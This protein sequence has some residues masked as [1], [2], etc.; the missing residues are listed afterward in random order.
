M[1]LKDGGVHMRVSVLDWL[2]RLTV[3]LLVFI[4]L[5]FILKLLPYARHF[6]FATLKLMSPFLIAFLIA[7]ILHPMVRH[8]HKRGMP[9]AL[10]II[11]IYLLFFGTTG[12]AAV[13]GTP[14]ILAQLG[15]LSQHIPTFTQFYQDK[16]DHFYTATDH[17]PEQVHVHFN[18]LLG[19]AQNALN[20]TVSKIMLSI[21]RLVTSIFT[22]FLIP[23]IV[24]YLLKD[25]RKIQQWLN[26]HAPDRWREPAKVLIHEIDHSLGSY[27]RGQ[28][29]VC[30]AVGVAAFIGLW[31]FKIPYPG[32]LGFFVGITDII[33]FFGGAIGAIPAVLVAMTFGF[34]KVIIVVA[35][36][37]VVQTL[38]GNLFSPVI[39]GKS[40]HLHP[41]FIML[42]LVV[43]G[44]LGGIIGLLIAVPVF[45]TGREIV[46]FII[47]ERRKKRQAEWTDQHI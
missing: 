44:E 22:I 42:S 32:V 8:L 5:W 26:E 29:L 27:I 12:Y 38:E 1:I 16:V 45:V 36:I 37:S 2:K 28:I 30:V 46:K 18:R 21:Q 11:I 33:P 7:Y 4:N 31:I 39:V 14:I 25:I 34:K 20:Q 23:F 41:V 15:S 24:F 9:R 3:L 40:V 17:L 19:K 47:N 43:G 6:L 13:K 10:A 35:V